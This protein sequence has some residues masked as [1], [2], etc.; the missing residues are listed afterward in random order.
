MTTFDPNHIIPRGA[1]DAVVK[2][3]DLEVRFM[4]D[5]DVIYLRDRVIAD[6]FANGK[7][8]GIYARAVMDDVDWRDPHEAIQRYGPDLERSLINSF[9][10]GL[11]NTDRVD[12]LEA[13]VQRLH[14]EIIA[15]RRPVWRKVVD[16]IRSWLP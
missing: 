15:L 14:E 13:Q 8:L 7:P 4:H 11:A 10:R 2:P 12:N 3:L 16:K 6:L 9:S 5:F 1:L